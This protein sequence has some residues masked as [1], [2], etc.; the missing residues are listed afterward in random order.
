MP[1]ARTTTSAP[2]ASDGRKLGLALAGGG[3]R[4]SLFHLGVLYRLA[5]LDLLRR[6]EVLSTV[7]GGSVIGA[8]YALLLKRERLRGTAG[9]SAT[10]AGRRLT[11]ADYIAL[12][13]ELDRRLTRAIK[14]NLRNALF[15]NPLGVIRVMFTRYTLAE[16]MSN[17]YERYLY[18]DVV[19]KLRAAGLIT[20]ERP[21]WKR[22]LWPGRIRL[23]DVRA[24]LAGRDLPGGIEAHNTAESTDADGCAVTK[25]VLNATC[26]N[27]GGRF[28]LSSSEI[29]DWYLGQ[30]RFSEVAILTQY[31]R[32]LRALPAAF[33]YRQVASGPDSVT[34]GRD[35]YARRTVLLAVWLRD[36]AADGTVAAGEWQE[37]FAGMAR[38]RTPL[39]RLA[40]ADPGA[41]RQAKLPAWFVRRGVHYEPPVLGGYTIAEHM[42]RLWSALEKIDEPLAHALRAFA[43]ASDARRDLL[44]DFLLE[45]Y[46][47]QSADVV[48]PTIARDLDRLTLGLAVGASAAFPP[49]FSP[50]TSFGFY[51]DAL[52]A[53]LGLTDGGVFDNMGIIALI[54]EGCDYI[55]ASD[56]SGVFV[57][58]Q[59]STM[60]RLG[61]P[62]RLMEIL[63]MDLASMQRGALRERR[64][65]SEQISLASEGHA[66]LRR[67]LAAAGV[68]TAGLDTVQRQLDAFHAPRRLK[69]LAYFG[70]PSPD[71]GTGA[72]PLRAGGAVIDRAALADT[73]TDLDGFGDAEIAALVLAGYDRADMYVRAYLPDF[74][75]AGSDE[76]WNA[77]LEPPRPAPDPD[78]INAVIR[79]AKHRFFRSLRL[80]GWWSLIPLT[81]TV[82][83][84]TALAFGLSRV[85]LDVAEAVMRL[86]DGIA[87]LTVWDGWRTI[88][89]GWGVLGAIGIALLVTLVRTIGS[90]GRTRRRWLGWL[91]K[92]ALGSAGLL[93]FFFGW[94]PA[95]AFVAALFVYAWVNWL[96]FHKPFLRLASLERVLPRTRSAR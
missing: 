50:I 78:R 69:G 30:F 85:R 84:A 44:L 82:A 60:T 45:L 19:A 1:D 63:M 76:L 31:R 26:V 61:L 86:P 23:Q 34:I 74:R 32:L 81:W 9:G 71:I 38:D 70:I 40:D 92:W 66:A 43:E 80:R 67:Q 39:D 46:W 53:R 62:A 54:D 55:I 24:Q 25:L 65:W 72:T 8:L 7:S 96:V 94:I 11:R 16:R 58:Q 64:R 73:R 59:S 90:R 33:T 88:P 12:V 18:R 20:D 21:F 47:L 28:W 15:W 48:S 14:L 49:V 3:F 35:A 42:D 75:P 13:Q 83:A 52:V 91:G 5:Q 89:L 95:A 77:P 29:G 10:P 27:S 57:R 51:D 17:L 93:V 41:L 68:P 22:W 79:V 36:R 6:V 37:L 4:A 2:S 87:R 56:T